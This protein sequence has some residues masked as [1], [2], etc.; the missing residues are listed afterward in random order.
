MKRAN[1]LPGAALFIAGLVLAGSSA[2][3]VA[4]P[5]A[6]CLYGSYYDPLYGCVRY[7]PVGYYYD[8]YYGCLPLPYL[9]GPPTY[10]YP[11]LGFLFFYGGRWGR[12]GHERFGHGGPHGRHPGGGRPPGGGH[13][14]GG[15]P[16]G[17]GHPG[18][19]GHRGEG[20][21]GHP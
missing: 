7:C 16:P 12:G 19:G 5:Y 1:T 4:Q 17:G 9:Y 21:R 13:P 2:R 18:G 8:S 10:V 14:G 15:R 3:V 11:D 6:Q 20:G